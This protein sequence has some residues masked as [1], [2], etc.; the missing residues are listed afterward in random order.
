MKET[1]I[2]HICCP[3]CKNVLQLHVFS[4]NSEN[5]REVIVNNK[6]DLGII[7]TGLLTCQACGVCYPIEYGIPVLLVFPTSFHD[8]FIKRYKYYLEKFKNFRMPSGEPRRGER[9]IQNSFTEEWN[10]AR[11][12]EVSFIY[13]ENDLVSL[14]KSVW[15]NWV[16]DNNVNIKSILNIGV[17]LG[18]E[19]MALNRL[20]PDSQ[21]I[22]VDL[23]FALLRSS[24]VRNSPTNVHFVIASL[25]DLPFRFKA[26]DFVYCQG[27]LHHTYSTQKAFEAISKFVSQGG[28]I[29][30]WVYGGD[31]NNIDDYIEKILR[32]FLSV[33]PK[34]IR[35]IIIF[36]LTAYSHPK[37][38]RRVLHPDL[39]TWKNTEHSIRD[40][41]T[42]RYAHRQNI[43]EV[44]E[45]F[46]QMGFKIIAFQS[47]LN[48]R[49]L[50]RSR[51]PGIGLAGKKY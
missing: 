37:F 45:W 44:T 18:Q 15:L 24:F 31:K 6:K 13:T 32:P 9:F 2:H 23:G 12:S 14:N 8:L 51:L 5:E 35:N 29:F 26:F 16:F 10:I 19:T 25:F 36:M 50:F 28:Y 33:S 34:I 39:W 4:T 30:I 43:N 11:D 7:D 41:F 40:K 21:L 22:G 20:F 49:E 1:L 3:I 17:G 46:E 48:Y 27:V 42:P 38:K 47:A